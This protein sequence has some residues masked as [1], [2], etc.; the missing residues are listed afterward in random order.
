MTESE[1]RSVYG[2]NITASKVGELAATK[3]A[4]ADLGAGKGPKLSAAALPAQLEKSNAEYVIFVGHNEEG[5]FKFADG[6][7]M[8]L[9]DMTEIATRAQKIPIFISCGAKSYVSEAIG[10]HRELGV[11][12]AIAATKVVVSFVKSRDRVS[13]QQIQEHLSDFNHKYR[14]AYVVQRGCHAAT[15]L[16]VVAIIVYLLGDDDD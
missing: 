11:S 7:S 8:S 3:K 5:T 13:A 6:T 12:E 9:S 2:T 15:G 10:V 4:M 1:Y 16:L 14:V